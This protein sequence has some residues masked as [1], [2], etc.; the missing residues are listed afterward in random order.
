MA[1]PTPPVRLEVMTRADVPQVHLVECICFSA[2]WDMNSYYSELQNPTAFYLTAKVEADTIGFGG[3]WVVE[4]EAHIVTLAV[5]PEFRR[6]GVGRQL[7]CALLREARRRRASVVTLEVRVS[8]TV[9]KTLYTCHGFHTIAYRRHYYPDNGED[10]AVM[11]LK[12]R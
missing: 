4:Q 11:E 2:P 6:H 7:L 12:L 9:A 8:N 5:K 1:M 3:M 10:A